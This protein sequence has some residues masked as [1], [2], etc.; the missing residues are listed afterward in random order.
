MTQKADRIE[1]GVY[2]GDALLTRE[3]RPVTVAGRTAEA[4][5]EFYRCTNCG[6]E[7]YLPGMMDA[8]IQRARTRIARQDDPSAGC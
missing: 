6:E 4:E 2:A 1:C 8:V 7:L 3:T 5:D